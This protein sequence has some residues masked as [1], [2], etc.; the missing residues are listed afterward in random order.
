VALGGKKLPTGA[1]QLAYRGG[2]ALVPEREKVFPNISVADHMRLVGVRRPGDIGIDGFDAI[3]RRW[4][5]RA[6]LLSGGERQMLALA[7]AW[8]HRPQVLLI[9]ELSLGL[10]PVITKSLL[11][12]VREQLAVTGGAVVVVEQDANAAVAVSDH[13]YVMDH[14]EIVWDAASSKTSAEALES[15]YLGGVLS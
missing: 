14:G 6:G 5:S 3:G 9:D 4:E 10:A 8:A 11:G 2:V 15:A 7:M 1:P 12:L 13:V